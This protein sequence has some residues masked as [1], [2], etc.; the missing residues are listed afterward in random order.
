MQLRHGQAVALMVAVTMMW[1][2]AGVVTRHLEYASSFEMTFWRSFF[3]ALA[4]LVILPLVQG[5]AVWRTLRDAGPSFWISGVCWCVMFTAFMVALT[6]SSVGNVLVTLAMGPLLT[7]LVARVM[8]GHQIAPRTWVA[9]ALAGAGIVWMFGSQVRAGGWAGSL[10][11]FCVPVAG[12]IN[13]TVTQRAHAKGLQIDLVPAVLAGAVISTLLTLPLA[14][15]FKASAHDVGLLALLGVVQLAIPCAL[16]VVCAR[17]LKAP[18]V[19]LLALLEVVFGIALAWVGANEAPAPQV[20]TGGALV[21]GAL[22]FNE[23]LGWRQRA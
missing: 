18:E 12:A 7:A 13:W 15:P 22:V 10:V 11:A 3:T 9:I 8:I 21:I 5:R 23:W 4:L 20:L 2:I 6:L 14:W 1:S 16:A 17:V 19:S